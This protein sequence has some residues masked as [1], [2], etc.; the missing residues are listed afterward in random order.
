MTTPPKKKKLAPPGR[1]KVAGVQDRLPPGALS[2]RFVE[3]DPSML[4]M[5]TADTRASPPPTKG[6]GRKPAGE[7]LTVYV[8][9]ELA[10]ALRVRC[11]KERRSL[12]DAATEALRQWAGG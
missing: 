1:V 11:A 5:T 10:E 2:R 12:S 6:N 4:T 3:E 9:P 7:R 8:P